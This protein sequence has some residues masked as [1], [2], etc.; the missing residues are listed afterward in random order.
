MKDNFFIDTNIVLYLLDV[1]GSRK[2][3]IASS[4]IEKTPFISPQVVFECL[5][6]CLRKLKMDRDLAT[7]FVAKLINACF[8]G[9]ENEMVATS[10]LLIFNKYLLQPFDS[11]IVASA[12]HADCNVLYSEDMQHGMI[13]ENRLTIINPFI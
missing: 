8:V 1:N 5:N 10:A 12:I 11:K 7:S 2:K 3:E 13:I 9:V 6:V 4:L